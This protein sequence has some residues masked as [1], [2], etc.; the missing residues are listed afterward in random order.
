MSIKRSGTYF[1]QTGRVIEETPFV[2]REILPAS[3]LEAKKAKKK[4][5]DLVEQKQKLQTLADQS[6]IIYRAKSVFPLQIFP[7]EIIVE[8]DKVTI[9]HRTFAWK[10][11]FPVLISNLNGVIATRSFFFASLSLE[12][13][14]Y[15]NNPDD[16]THLWPEDAARVK[17]YILGLI[18]ATKQGVD[19]S[20]I[21]LEELKENVEEIGRTSGEIETLPIM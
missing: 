15:E 4:L 10:N 17:R 2:T 12:L 5:T 7:D 11:V 3:S 14:G 8:R 6:N 16:I 9:V 19:V 20:K 1:A 18:H 13:T 21:P